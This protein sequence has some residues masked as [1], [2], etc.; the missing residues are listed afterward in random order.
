MIAVVGEEVRLVRKYEDVQFSSLALTLS[1]LRFAPR[2]SLLAQPHL[3]DFSSSSL[4]MRRK[5]DR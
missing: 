2:S 1:A 3:A 5:P 4:V